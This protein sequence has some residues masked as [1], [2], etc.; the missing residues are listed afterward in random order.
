MPNP[1][2]LADSNDPDTEWRPVR[3]S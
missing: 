1:P 2:E 3:P